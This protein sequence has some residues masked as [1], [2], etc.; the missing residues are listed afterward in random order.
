MPGLLRSHHHFIKRRF[1]D[2]FQDCV[3]ISLLCPQ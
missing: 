2:W 1:G 3:F